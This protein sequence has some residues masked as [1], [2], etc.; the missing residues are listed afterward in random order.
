M[1]FVVVCLDLCVRLASEDVVSRYPDVFTQNNAHMV[2]SI[3]IALEPI[4]ERH[5]VK[6]AI[7]FD[8]FAKGTA[9]ANSDEYI[10]FDFYRFNDIIK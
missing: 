7:L 3:R 8:S 9:S 1:I 2:D 6:K 5:Q 10:I 4:F